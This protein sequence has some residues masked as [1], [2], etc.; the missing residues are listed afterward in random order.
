MNNKTKPNYT[1]WSKEA[2]DEEIREGR[3]VSYER[4]LGKHMSRRAIAQYNDTWASDHGHELI[5][6]QSARKYAN[7]LAES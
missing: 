7:E 1:A 6:R 3:A 5:T 4:F 2:T